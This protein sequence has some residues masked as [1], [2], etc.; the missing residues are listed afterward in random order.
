V[1][2]A[3]NKQRLES[4]PESLITPLLIMLQIKKFGMSWFSLKEKVMINCER[5]FLIINLATLP[6][7]LWRI[8]IAIIMALFSSHSQ[9]T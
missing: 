7:F 1:T 4:V 2:L 3:G 8:Y 5:Y 9:L 6:N